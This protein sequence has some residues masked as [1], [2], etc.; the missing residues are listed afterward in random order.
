MTRKGYSAAI[1]AALAALLAASCQQIFTTSLVK[2]L[3]RDPSSL[4][5][6]QSISLSE[7][8]DYWQKY[9]G[10]QAIAVQLVEPLFTIIQT[11][12]PG[13]STYDRAANLLT[14]AIITS[15]GFLAATNATIK[16]L[17]KDLSSVDEE[18]IKQVVS[19]F[20]SVELSAT[21]I[22]ALAAIAIAPPNSL[23]SDQAY[24]VAGALLLQAINETDA[25]LDQID[26]I[27]DHIVAIQDTRAYE[28]AMLFLGLA[29]DTPTTL[30]G[31]ILSDLANL[32]QP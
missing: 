31:G 4:K 29:D 9:R 16:A 11:T 19:S 14:D 12:T 22:E 30:I 10:N 18:A 27:S 8:E 32:L 1:A 3:A 20:S 15:S 21:E 5:L 2:G 26:N 7:A 24:Q 23:S 13:T 25:S 17:P 28:V 6:P